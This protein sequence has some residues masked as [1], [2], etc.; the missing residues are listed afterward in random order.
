MALG[1]MLG[2]CRLCLVYW[3][4]QRWAYSGT[5][6]DDILAGQG[7]LQ[8]QGGPGTLAGP[9]GSQWLG[10]GLLATFGGSAHTRND[11]RVA[12]RC[13]HQDGAR[14]AGADP[15]HPV[16]SNTNKGSGF[17]KEK[18]QKFNGTVVCWFEAV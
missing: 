17:N 1:C 10:L 7:R 15:R 16:L 8:A 13:R 14:Q 11:E 3:V 4:L 2:T 5:G 18:P 12:M 9:G 6:L